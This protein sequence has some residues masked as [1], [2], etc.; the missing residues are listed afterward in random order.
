MANK[1]WTMNE[2][3]KA[4]IEILKGYEN[5]ATLKDIELDTGKVFK[6]GS[7]NTLVSKGLVSVSDNEVEVEVH[8]RG[9]VIGKLTKSWKVYKLVNK[10]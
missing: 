7:I 6:T 3:Q 5:G 4:F 1:T 9:A 10:D 8:Y 2:T